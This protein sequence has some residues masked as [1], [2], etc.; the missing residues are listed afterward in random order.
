MC[1]EFLLIAPRGSF[2]SVKASNLCRGLVASVRHV[3]Q[4]PKSGSKTPA[5]QPRH[6]VRRSMSSSRR[7]IIQRD[8]SSQLEPNAETAALNQHMHVKIQHPGAFAV[9]VATNPKRLVS[10]P[11][12]PRAAI[13]E[14]CLC[15]R[16][17]TGWDIKERSPSPKLQ[18]RC[19]ILWLRRA[20]TV[21][22]SR[23]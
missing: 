22:V 15:S 6:L 4:D 7:G 13:R 8:I 3:H 14:P 12:R 16:H 17:Q 2:T 20:D 19:W 1:L 23:V 18:I 11:A 9:S 21:F 5:E 10:D